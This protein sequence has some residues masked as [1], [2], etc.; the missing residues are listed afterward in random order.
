MLNKITKLACLL[1][2]FAG[3]SS[4]N[5]GKSDRK[6]ALHEMPGGKYYGGVFRM[7]ESEY[8]RS[9]YPLNITEVVG[10][11]IVNQVYEGLI[12][13]DQADL[14]IKPCLADSWNISPDARIY[15]FYLHKGVK[16]HDD[17]CFPSGK[18]RE[19]KAADFKKSLD[20]L[21]ETDP[22]NQGFWVFQDLVSG[23]DA[24]H[25]SC[26]EKKPLK[27]GVSGIE[28]LDEYTLRIMLDRPFASFL[29]KLATPFCYV[30]PEEAIQR[31]GME[32]REHAVGTGPFRVKRIVQDES[33]FLERNPDYWGKDSFGNKLPYL[34]A[35][36]YSFIKEDKVE[37]FEFENGKL[38]MKY[39]IP[40]DMFETVIGQ[41]GKLT[42]DYQKFQLQSTVEMS[43]QYYGFLHQ[44]KI[45]KDV[46][47]RKAFCYA[48]DREKLCEYTI[49]GQGVPASSGLVPPCFRDFHNKNVKGYS[50]DANKAKAALEKAGYPDGK[51]FPEITLQLNSGGGRNINVAEAVKKMIE[52]TLNIKI[53]ISQM[54][55]AQHSEN[56]ETGKANFWRLGW[57]ADYPDPENYLNLL[58]GIHVPKTLN[59]K[60]YINSFRYVNADYDKIFKEAIQTV[61]DSVRNHLYEMADQKAMD[62]AVMLCLFYDK[63]FRL[64]QPNVRNFPQNPMEYRLLRETYFVPLP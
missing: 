56:I 10:H 32:M 9:L 51:G 58:Y 21:C 46:N 5:N 55:W 42:K 7:N 4:C 62:D 13:L 8:F 24:Y 54:V 28:V 18:G 47:V 43:T 64:I 2:L 25:K 45:F 16:F 3:I 36:K 27:G 40:L 38:D 52:E 53:N 17:P 34:D 60:A 33:V 31:Y 48:V 20:R 59:E 1:V 29:A 61:N 44:D 12:C 39:R 50:Y 26:E 15:T 49:K 19:V 11:R 35:V 14:H 57:V 6:G 63:Q 41:D 23:A 30:I 37:M 22:N